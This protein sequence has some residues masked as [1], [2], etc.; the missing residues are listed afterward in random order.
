M[1]EPSDDWTGYDAGFLGTPVPLPTPL[2]DTAVRELSYPRFTVLLDPVRRLALATGV[3]IDGAE[4][5]DLPRTGE[6]HLDTRVPASAQTGPAVYVAN[7][8]DRGHL[9][10]RR[11]PG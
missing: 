10:R 11:D 1:A 8:L 9:V 4:L 3:N 2:G 7:D 6:W 5:Q